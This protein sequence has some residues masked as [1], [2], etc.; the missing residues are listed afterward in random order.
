MKFEAGQT[1]VRIASGLDKNKTSTIK[2]VRETEE[3]YG[4]F[5]ALSLDMGYH[6]EL[7][8][9][10]LDKA[11]YIEF[12]GD[13]ITSG[14]G[15]L[16][17]Y[18][19]D[20][21]LEIKNEQTS[22]STG[23]HKCGD[24]NDETSLCQD[25]TNSYAYLAA[26]SLGADCSFVSYSGIGVAKGYPDF[27]MSDYFTYASKC[28]NVKYTFSTARKP[29]LV[30]INLGTNDSFKNADTEAFKTE[31]KALIKQV[32][33]AYGEDTEI[34]WATGLMSNEDKDAYKTYAAAAISELGYANVHH[35]DGLTEGRGGHNGHPTKDQQKTAAEQLVNKIAE[36]AI[37]DTQKTAEIGSQH[38][39]AGY[40]LAWS[41]GFSGSS[42]S[43]TKM[44]QKACMGEN[45]TLKVK[46]ENLT[47]ENG[48]AVLSAKY[49]GKNEAGENVYSA[50]TSLTTKDVMAFRYGYV[51]MRAKVPTGVPI[52]PS[53]WLQ[54]QESLRN[55]N[56]M[57]EVDIFEVFANNKVSSTYHK[58]YNKEIYGDKYHPMEGM[59]SSG[60]LPANSS[61][62][63]HTYAME[64]TPEYIKM[65]FDGTEYG[66]IEATADFGE[67]E[68]KAAR[69]PGFDDPLY[70]I[71]NNHVFTKDSGW[72]PSDAQRA[73]DADNGKFP[74]DYT[75]DYIRIYQ[76]EAISNS[77]IYN[78][79]D[80]KAGNK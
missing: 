72:A 65:Y 1:S 11:A 55:S 10:P 35:F 12:L 9:K 8:D 19:S 20:D 29:D 54:S 53:L 32:R 57:T 31:V 5:T 48:T 24:S 40:S 67:A 74:I 77:K 3:K 66:K 33:T 64:W 60:E 41:E 36:L 46:K 70:L 47:I 26:E 79:A 34:L 37:V 51:E 2:L 25:A 50:V 17:G 30:V 61:N 15:S 18:L 56:Y 80:I 78:E 28:R 14:L 69:I 38:V 39:P 21:G 71:L 76:S 16:C 44:V 63:Y 73:T 7:G 68:P 22:T 27:T 49:E 75:V 23:K 58:W 4:A 52:W 45:A 6:G 62:E 13:S 59:G 43:D 42:I